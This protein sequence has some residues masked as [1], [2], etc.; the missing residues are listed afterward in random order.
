MVVY[1]PETKK[2]IP[3]QGRVHG[4][5]ARELKGL[6]GFGYDPLF[7]VD[8]MNK[9]M[10]ELTR[11]EKNKVSHRGRALSKLVEDLENEVISI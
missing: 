7:I 3:Y 10:G 4:D 5:I 1:F 9:R 11:E 6:S 8:G 2:F